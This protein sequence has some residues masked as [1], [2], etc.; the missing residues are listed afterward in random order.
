M[1]YFRILKKHYS[2]NMTLTSKHKYYLQSYFFEKL[3]IDKRTHVQTKSI[4]RNL[5]KIEK[6]Q[7]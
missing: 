7:I 4:V 5:T 2:I 3:F 6:L 1:F